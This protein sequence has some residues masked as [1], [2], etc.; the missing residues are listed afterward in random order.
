GARHAHALFTSPGFQHL[1]SAAAHMVTIY[2]LCNDLH[3]SNLLFFNN[4]TKNIY[5]F[6]TIFE[7]MPM[8]ISLPKLRGF[9]NLK[10]LSNGDFLESRYRIEKKGMSVEKRE[11][12]RSSIGV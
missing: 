3:S 9:G 1:I 8:L 5:L 6:N 2:N 4:P 12:S 11:M 10:R 7:L